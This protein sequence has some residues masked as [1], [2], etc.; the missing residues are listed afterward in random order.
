MLRNQRDFD[1]VY[2]KGKSVPSRHVVIF[3]RRTRRPETRIAFLASKKVGNS[4]KRNRAR[5]LMRAALRNS[6]IQLEP[7]V[8]YIFIA[9]NSITGAKCPEVE[10]SLMSAFRRMGGA[11]NEG[12]R[13]RH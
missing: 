4:V 1:Q 12:R 5:R 13:K 6:G 11:K 8:D 10:K 2:R 3:Y 7:G 9:R